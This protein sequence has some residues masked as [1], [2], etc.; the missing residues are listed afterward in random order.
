MDSSTFIPSLLASVPEF[1]AD[2]EDVV[3]GLTYPIA[4]D[5][6]RAVCER[7]WDESF[8]ASV[9]DFLEKACLTGDRD[10]VDLIDECLITMDESDQMQSLEGHLKANTRKLLEWNR[11]HRNKSGP[12]RP[13][14]LD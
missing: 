2:P 8:V 1:I 5:L 12:L 10:V 9:V 4:N 11:A 7:S 14:L 3:D 6:G 13:S